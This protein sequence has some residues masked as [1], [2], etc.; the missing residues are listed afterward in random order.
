VTEKAKGAKA[1]DANL[2][3]TGAEAARSGPGTG[4]LEDPVLQRCLN[5][6]QVLDAIAGQLDRHAGNFYIQTDP[7]GQVTGVTGIDLDM[8]FGQDMSDPS[9]ANKPASAAHYRGVPALVDYDLGQRLLAITEADIEAAI[10]GLLSDAEVQ[11]TKQRFRVVQDHARQ[12][13]ASHNLTAAWNA[14]T[15]RQ[16][17][18]DKASKFSFEF[19]DIDSYT[20]TLAD[21][22]ADSARLEKPVV[23]AL[24]HSFGRGGGDPLPEWT[25]LQDEV[26]A[27]QAK[28]MEEAITNAI[29]ARIQREAFQG[30]IGVDQ[31]SGAAVAMLSTLL[32][33]MAFINTLIVALQEAGTNID[34]TVKTKV[35]QLPLQPGAVVNAGGGGG[36]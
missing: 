9:I 25:R 28:P 14:Q 32:Q 5:K 13:A 6:L 4:S 36:N 21:D 26:Y 3:L 22:R 8:A 7:Q 24:V 2:K 12:L 17:R 35:D 11:A 10:K 33:D 30:H 1:S 29:S 18:G 31:A 15:A 16:G 19:S 23:N 20:N 34:A 27:E